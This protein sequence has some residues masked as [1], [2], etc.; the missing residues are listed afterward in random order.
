[1]VRERQD[2]LLAPPAVLHHGVEGLLL[3]H[4]LVAA[5]LGLPA[6]EHGLEVDIPGGGFG[7]LRL[8]VRMDTA[9]TRLRNLRSTR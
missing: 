5:A 4:D 3:G 2:I 9:G 7:V 6:A 8:V 1:M